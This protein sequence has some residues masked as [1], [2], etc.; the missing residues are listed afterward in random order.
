MNELIRGEIEKNAPDTLQKPSIFNIM[1]PVK[2]MY[3]GLVYF[4]QDE[5]NFDGRI[6]LERDSCEKVLAHASKNKNL[7]KICISMSL[8]KVRVGSVNC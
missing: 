1:Y 7:R 5:D 6:M 2:V 4:P 3:L 8:L